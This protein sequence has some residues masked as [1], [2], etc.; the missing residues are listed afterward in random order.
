MKRNFKWKLRAALVTTALL[1]LMAGWTSGRSQNV[2]MQYGINVSGTSGTGG[3]VLFF[4]DIIY[5]PKSGNSDT[6]YST[7]G[8]AYVTLYGNFL[9]GASV[10]LNNASCLV[11]VSPPTSWLWYQRMVVQLKNTCSS[12][13]FVV[14]TSAGTSNGIPFTIALGTIYYVATTGTDGAAGT[15]SAP[16]RTMPYAVQHAGTSPGNIVY[17][18]SNVQAVTDDGQWKGDLTIRAGWANGTA[19]QPNAIIGYPGATGIVIGTSAG[20]GFD[21]SDFTAGDGAPAGYWTVAELV[22]IGQAAVT[23]SGGAQWRII[24]NDMSCPTA[25]GGGGGGACMETSMVSMKTFGN[26]LHDLAPNSTDRLLH[27]VYY[28]TDS[29]GI[30]H[31][32]NMEYNSGGRAG[33][34]THSSPLI[35]GNGYILNSYSIHD[36]TIHD[37]REECILLDTTD[38]SAGTGVYVYN[39]VLFNCATDGA[40]DSLHQQL[41]GDFDTSH[42]LGSSPPPFNWYNNTVLISN[43]SSCWGASYPDIHTGITVTNFEQNNLC[44]VTGTAP[45][46]NP[47]TYTGSSCGNTDNSTTCQTMT[48][49]YDLVYGNGVAT[50]PNLMTHQVNSNPS[51]VNTTVTGCPANCATNLHFLS[52]SSPAKGAGTTAAPTPI[53]D[54]DGKIRPSPPSI[55]AYEF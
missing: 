35:Q 27:G 45:Y 13:N 29:N 53:Y 54:H 2:T 15:Y 40:G 19:S 41:S 6:T 26:N 9:T 37:A 17:V 22:F 51:L 21:T 44:L 52:S 1:M 55:G 38:P 23:V 42:G 7:G 14:T 5:G 16:W 18:R 8:G 12:G 48:G 4:S 10:T 39:N 49:Q 33:I 25:T 43:G 36:N 3:P 50:F 20:N 11:V 30:E 24:G 47:E 28:S 31:A 46:W 34:Q 32:W